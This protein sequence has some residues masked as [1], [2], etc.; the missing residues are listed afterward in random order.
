MEQHL[1][2]PQRIAYPL[3][4]LME[5]HQQYNSIRLKNMEIHEKK[6]KGGNGKK[7]LDSCKLNFRGKRI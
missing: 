3:G 6:V 7:Q 2:G 4:D 1:D 5:T